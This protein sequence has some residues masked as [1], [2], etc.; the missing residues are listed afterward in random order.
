[1]TSEEKAEIL[2]DTFGD[3]CNISPHHKK[4][5]R[6]VHDPNS[7][8][9]LVRQMILEVEEIPATQ[10]PALLE[11]LSKGQK[12]EFSDERLQKFLRSKE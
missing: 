3:V 9:F 1:M 11:A 4:R 10:K 6:L 2:A 7:V 5:A 8:A 12:E